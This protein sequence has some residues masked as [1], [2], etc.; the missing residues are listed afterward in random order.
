M[1]GF[2]W[3]NPF[4]KVGRKWANGQKFD[5]NLKFSTVFFLKNWALVKNKWALAKSSDTKV[6]RKMTCYYKDF[7][8]RLAEIGQKLRLW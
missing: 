8:P 2:S 1:L 3:P 7:L 6:G 5:Q 4:L